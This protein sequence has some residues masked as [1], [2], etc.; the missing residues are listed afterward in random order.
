MNISH[1]V[2][3]RGAETSSQSLSMVLLN[4]AQKNSNLK[5]IS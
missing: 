1:D 3:V 4:N 2:S 5:S